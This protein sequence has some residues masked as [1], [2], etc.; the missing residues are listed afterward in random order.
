MELIFIYWWSNMQFWWF[1]YK[2]KYNSV[3][4]HQLY[5]YLVL[6]I[7]ELTGNPIWYVSNRHQSIHILDHW[8]TNKTKLSILLHPFLNYF[9]P[10]INELM[11]KHIFYVINFHCLFETQMHVFN[12]WLINRIN[13]SIFLVCLVSTFFQPSWQSNVRFQSDRFHTNL[14]TIIKF[15]CMYKSVHNY[16]T[17]Y[18]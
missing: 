16:H 17:Q 9:L 7:K 12:C 2:S 14:S 13:N 6:I 5:I 1:I 3:S 10:I 11:D 8:W 4:F 18:N 15:P